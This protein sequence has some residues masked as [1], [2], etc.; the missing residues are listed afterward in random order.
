MKNIYIL[1]LVLLI[2]N[3]TFGQEQPTSPIDIKTKFTEFT[4]KA[5]IIMSYEDYNEVKISSM[6]YGSLIMKKRIVKNG[7]E[8]KVFYVLEKPTKYS[9]RTAAIA[10]I[11]FTDLLEA[12]NT[13]INDSKVDESTSSDYMEKFYKTEDNFKFGYFVS[14][15]KINWFVDLDTRLSDSIFFIDKIDGFVEKLKS[16]MN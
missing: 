9:T 6:M 16:I 2:C 12:V 5:G 11:D 14:K 7:G 15:N 3:T 8:Q 1:S 10:E 13:L 4:A